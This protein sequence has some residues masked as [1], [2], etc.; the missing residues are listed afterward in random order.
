MQRSTCALQAEKRASAHATH[1]QPR[2]TK[3]V[4]PKELFRG[5]PRSRLLCEPI[6]EELD[7]PGTEG[8]ALARQRLQQIKQ[9]TASVTRTMRHGL[10]TG[11]EPERPSR[12]LPLPL[13]SELGSP[14]VHIPA[15]AMQPLPQI[16]QR[17][18]PRPPSLNSLDLSNSHRTTMAPPV[19]TA[20][21]T[22]VQSN[23]DLVRTGA[24]AAYGPLPILPSQF[25]QQDS[26][27]SVWS[28][29]SVR[30]YSSCYQDQMHSQY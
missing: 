29:P 11:C 18:G 10:R 7:R 25:S 13:S 30:K 19:S 20:L 16:P 14:S 5:R 28:V 2:G 21:R 24:S 4:Q 17:T 27:Q 23:Q 3:S 9:R 22:S 8:S 12:T 6:V 26:P 1:D 15:L